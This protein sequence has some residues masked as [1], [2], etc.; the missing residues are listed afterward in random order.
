M[1]GNGISINP[2]AFPK[3]NDE[4][5]A[6]RASREYKL[7]LLLSTYEERTLGCFHLTWIHLSYINDFHNRNETLLWV[8]WQTCSHTMQFLSCHILL[9]W[10]H[11]CQTCRRDGGKQAYLMKWICINS[12]DFAVTKTTRMSTGEVFTSEYAHFSFRWGELISASC[13]VAMRVS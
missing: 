7:Q 8:M 11:D 13:E 6:P 3:G 1:N 2:L 4:M 9:V 10:I 5:P 12:S